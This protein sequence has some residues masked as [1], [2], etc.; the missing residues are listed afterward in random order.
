MKGG[1]GRADDSGREDEYQ[2]IRPALRTSESRKSGVALR[3][4]RIDSERGLQSVSN[5]NPV[6]YIFTRFVDNTN[7]RFWS[8][9]D[10]DS[11]PPPSLFFRIHIA[12]LIGSAIARASAAGTIIN[13]LSPPPRV[14]IHTS[15]STVIAN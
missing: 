13:Q 11:F 8:R 2:L 10:T 4:R 15:V 6:F 5:A 1:T 3:N 9:R 14:F 7:S 12:Q